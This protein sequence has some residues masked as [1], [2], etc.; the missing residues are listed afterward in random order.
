MISS[1][2][3]CHQLQ[4]PNYF[5]HTLYE[6]ITMHI[7]LTNPTDIWPGNPITAGW[8]VLC[9]SIFVITNV[10][11]NKNYIPI[12]KAI[13]YELILFW[14]LYVYNRII[15]SDHKLKTQEMETSEALISCQLAKPW[16]IMQL[17]TYYVFEQCS[18]I[19][20]LC[21][22]ITIPTVHIYNF[23]NFNN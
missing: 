9:N 20:P 13:C 8:N 21:S 22:I 11:S 2:E 10:S 16:S 12:Y 3:K 14:H 4:L 1:R 6:P 5:I 23:I 18:K 7:W 15:I 19:Y 17:C